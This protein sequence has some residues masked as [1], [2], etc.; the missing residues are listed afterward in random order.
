MNRIIEIG[1]TGME[2]VGARKI[3]LLN[4]LTLI[5]LT[6]S[7][8][9]LFLYIAKGALIPAGTN[10]VLIL[11]YLFTFL[12]TH[13]KKHRLAKMWLH[14]LFMLHLFIYSSLVFTKA[15]GFHFY[16]LT[17]P[18]CVFLVFEY[19]RIK[20]KYILST[21]AVLLFFICEVITFQPPL[22]ALTENLN[23]FLYFST[24]LSIFLGILIIIYLFTRDIKYHEDKQAALIG[25][26]ETALSEVHTLKGF[27]PICSSCKKIRDDSGYW[28]Q[29]ETYIQSHSDAEFSHSICPD[30]MEK[31]YGNEDWFDKRQFGQAADKPDHRD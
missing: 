15:T 5:V 7:L 18:P 19:Q 12:L 26:L 29:I 17:I 4:L 2:E 1:T 14:T 3:R 23:R 22:I 9:Y 21:A 10:L 25:E 24:I 13:R 31:I 11:L 30:C 28:N 20:D 16:F 27:L 8:L 6:G